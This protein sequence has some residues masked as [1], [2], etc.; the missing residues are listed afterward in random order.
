MPYSSSES[1]I[2]WGVYRVVPWHMQGIYLSEA[3]ANGEAAKAGTQYIVDYGCLHP[4]TGNFTLVS[5]QI[6]P[7]FHSRV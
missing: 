7:P 3:K 2:G 1:Q 5:A 4:A 6:L